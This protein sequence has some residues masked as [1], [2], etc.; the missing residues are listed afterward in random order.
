MKITSNVCVRQ[1]STACWP[2]STMVIYVTFAR[3]RNC[4]PHKELSNY[5]PLRLP[6]SAGAAKQWTL[7]PLAMYWIRSEVPGNSSFPRLL[8]LTRRVLPYWIRPPCPEPH[9]QRF[10][11][12]SY[13]NHPRRPQW[14]WFEKGL[15][16]KPLAPTASAWVLYSSRA[17]AETK[18][19][20]AVGSL[21]TI[22]LIASIPTIIETCISMNMQAKVDV[23]QISTAFWP[24]STIVMPSMPAHPNT[25]DNTF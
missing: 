1:T 10:D 4:L 20:K 11:D 13:S 25:L 24:L 15:E 12:F 7:H 8:Y 5:A 9:P 3:F 17:C 14:H 19:T 2:L 18:S 6:W 22:V 16:K 23:A 21:S